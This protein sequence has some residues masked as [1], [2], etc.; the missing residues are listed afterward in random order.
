MS[1]LLEIFPREGTI[2]YVVSLGAK[3]QEPTNGGT[4]GD[5]NNQNGS[6]TNDGTTTGQ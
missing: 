2:S 3:P 1:P 4:T 6:N 5:N